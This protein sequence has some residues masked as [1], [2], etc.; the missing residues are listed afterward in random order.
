MDLAGSTKIF[1]TNNAEY[2]AKAAIIATG[3]SR[4][5]LDIC[6]EKAFQGRG[7]SYCATCDGRF[8]E[9]KVVAV[10]GGGRTAIFDAI[11]LSNICKQVYVIPD[12]R[13][14]LARAQREAA[15]RGLR[16]LLC[17]CALDPEKA[18]ALLL[19]EAGIAFVTEEPVPGDALRTETLAR[20]LAQLR[21]AKCLHD[22]LE[23]I[24]R[25]YVDFTALTGFTDRTIEALFP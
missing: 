10:V 6:G 21:E 16:T 11:Y 12:G 8:F 20:A 24:S 9:G 18:E 14:S 15:A 4:K 25:P 2:G 5:K 17:P 3:A 23:A 7:V 19:P 13:G 1:K 22:E